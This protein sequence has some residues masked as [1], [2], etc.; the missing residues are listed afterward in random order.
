MLPFDEKLEALLRDV[1]DAE[2]ARLFFE[3]LSAESPRA[4]RLLLAGDAGLV[5][6]ALAL[7]A[8]SPLLAT[9]LA[10]HPEYLTWLARERTQSRVKTTEEIG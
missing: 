4:A 3:R 5:A 9:T 8:W 7:A 1:P 2:G 6:D 10:Q